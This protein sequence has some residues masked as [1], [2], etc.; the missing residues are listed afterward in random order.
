MPESPFNERAGSVSPDGK[1]LA[2]VSNESGRDEV[3]AQPFPGPGAKVAISTD[4]GFAPAWSRN[5]RELFYRRL[6]EL[7]VVQIDH[8]P[9]RAGSP[10]R[11]FDFP[12]TI[13]GRDPNRVEYD[14]APDGRFLAVR[15]DARSTGEE[16]RVVTNWL[17]DR[18]RAAATPRP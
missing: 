3:Y 14:V 4:G 13:Y 12:M 8:D 9:T 1:W 15:A 6:D 2:F 16:I 18:T 10:R 5:G 11:L 17:A 7:M